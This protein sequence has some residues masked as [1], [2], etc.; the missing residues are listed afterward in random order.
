MSLKDL[1]FGGATSTIDIIWGPDLSVSIPDDVDL[2][3]LDTALERVSLRRYTNLLD[4][5]EENDVE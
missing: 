3:K 5:E 1:L 4:K 2:K